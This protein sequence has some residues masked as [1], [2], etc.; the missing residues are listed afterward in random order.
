MG[1]YFYTKYF[2]ILGWIYEVL[3]NLYLSA[4]TF[5]YPR[6]PVL[7]SSYPLLRALTPLCPL[8]LAL[9]HSYQVL[10]ALTSSFLLLSSLTHSCLL[11][12]SYPLF[13]ALICF[14]LFLPTLQLS[15]MLSLTSLSQTDLL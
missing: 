14:Y 4:P 15:Y 11:N 5:S 7:S 3:R 2:V 6:L 1:N 13:S 10:P 12:N 8:L 9:T